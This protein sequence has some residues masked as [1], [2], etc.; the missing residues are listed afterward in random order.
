MLSI[1]ESGKPDAPA[2]L[3]LHGG[4]LSGQSWLP[5]MK[6][7]GDFHCLAPDLPGQGSSRDVPY[8][9]E[10]CVDECADIIRGKTK[11]RRAQ[12]VALSLGG[13]VAFRLAATHPDMIDHI[14]I[15]GSSGQIPRWLAALGKPSLWLYK[16]YNPDFLIRE[17]MR[18][19]G[20]PKQYA[21]LVEDDLRQSLD[22]AFMRRFMDELAAWQ[23][24][25]RIDQ[26]LLLAVG[27]REPR[28]ARLFTRK[29]LR[30]F[31]AARGILVP[32]ARHAWSLQFPELF[33]SLVR[34][35]IEG[36]PLPPEFKPLSLG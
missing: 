34:A 21:H 16:L 8:S 22:A 31:Q 7:L 14:L 33:A 26:P 2:I 20:I 17:T 6:I 18:Q 27:E 36:R 11:T 13:P 15:S 30:R 29:Y 19:H 9:I 12:I 5:V 23:L 1:L 10:R 4:G 32:G 35:W 24:P 3:F 25:E 28:A